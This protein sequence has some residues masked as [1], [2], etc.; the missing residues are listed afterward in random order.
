M[1]VAPRGRP[2]RVVGMRAAAGHTGP[3]A[4]LPAAQLSAIAASVDDLAGRCAELATRVEADGDSEAT[5]ALYEAERSL[6]VAGRSLER[7]RRS[8]GG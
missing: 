5:T 1:R 6:L 4:S 7:A 3:M 2:T 8:L